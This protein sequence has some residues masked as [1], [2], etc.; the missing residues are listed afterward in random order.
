[1]RQMKTAFLLSKSR[2]GT[3]TLKTPMLK[4]LEKMFRDAIMKL[5]EESSV[6]GSWDKLFRSFN[7]RKTGQIPAT[8]KGRKRSSSKI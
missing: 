4:L 3:E 1:M 8:E 7:E 6:S 5:T 2:T